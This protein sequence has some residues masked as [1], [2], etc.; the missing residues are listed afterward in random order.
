MEASRQRVNFKKVGEY[1]N[2]SDHLL[3]TVSPELSRWR[4]GEP[5]NGNETFRDLPSLK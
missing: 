5:R 3:C 1:A 2:D 4:L